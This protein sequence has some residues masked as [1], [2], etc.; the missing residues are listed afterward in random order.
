MREQTGQASTDLVKVNTSIRR[1]GRGAA[2]VPLQARIRGGSSLPTTPR[3]SSC[4][5]HFRAEESGLGE[6]ECAGYSTREGR[7]QGWR[8]RG[9]MQLKKAAE[10][11]RGG[12]ERATEGEG[13]SDMWWRG[14]WSV[15]AYL[16][17]WVLQHW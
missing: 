15:N 6:G 17:W 11:R 1:E 2:F 10:R 3:A 12:R 9:E 16:S 7:G 8:N 13:F 5:P 14:R 4:C